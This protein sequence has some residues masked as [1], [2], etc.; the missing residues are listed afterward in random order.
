M[1]KIYDVIVVGELNVDLIL[2]QIH[3]FT[4]VGKE[5][6][7][8]KMTLT[9][10]SSSAICASNLS[11]LGCR[12]AFVGK[13]GNDI[14]GNYTIGQLQEKGVDTSMIIVDDNL[15]TGAT[16]ALSYEEDRAMV[17]H[18]GAMS[19]LNI[20]DIDFEKLNLAKHLHFSSY[21]FQPGFKK[22]LH[23]LFKKVKDM[24]DDNVI[25][26]SMGSFRE[27]GS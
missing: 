10:G 13:L 16:I 27:M 23:V 2:N 4:E 26:C 20:D 14:F 5:I 19:Y 1:N 6:L 7:A 15:K 9:L 25:G 8:D 24:G 22:T 18:Q 3:G 17:T 21:F 12:V 11:S